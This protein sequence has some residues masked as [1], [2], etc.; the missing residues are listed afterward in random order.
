MFSNL[1]VT[2]TGY[3]ISGV[4]MAMG[5]VPAMAGMLEIAK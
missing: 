1:F 3:S 4:G 2:I 5:L